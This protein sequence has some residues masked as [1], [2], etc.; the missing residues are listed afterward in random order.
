[1]INKSFVI[2]SA[3][4]T[5]LILSTGGLIFVFN[6]N[7]MHAIYFG[8]IATVLITSKVSPRKNIFNASIY[9]I[10]T[11]LTIYVVNFVFAVN[12]QAIEKFLF[13]FLISTICILVAYHF[14]NN[15]SVERFLRVLYFCLQLIF[16]HS[17]F[18]FL[19]F[20]LVKNNL[21][22]LTS[23]FHECQTFFN[24]FFY[25]IEKSSISI[26]NIDFCRNQG[27]FWEPGILQAYLNLLFFLEAFYF[28]NRKVFLMLIAFVVITTY[29]TAGLTILLI[30]S[31][32][33]IYEEVKKS[34]IF[35]FIAVLLL[36]PVIFIYSNNIENKIKGDYESSFQKRLFDLTQP[37]FIALQNPITG[38]GL[39]VIQFQE[40]RKEFYFNSKR[41]NF[42]QDQIG[43]Q[44]KSKTTE[45]GSS[46]SVMF[47]LATLGFPFT[48][49]LLYFVFKQ[50]F[51]EQKK[52]LFFIFFFLTIMS[53]PLL[54]RP[55][56]FIFII[57]GMINI[58]SKF[59]INTDL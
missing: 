39:D 28:K 30:Q 33:Y 23:A 36:V 57:S 1:M 48:I 52:I 54:L 22:T 29:S 31:I 42:L 4:V 10:L 37:F 26:F 7:L 38:V 58:Y 55:F 45:K 44:S 20:F 21:Q 11:I 35:G 19:A 46:N 40:V 47:L 43:I 9:S 25:D 2:D 53:Q 32:V 34:K 13:N 12:E 50:S 15:R 14:I 17:L 6:R 51:F 18:N 56:F 24:I 27:L 49:L 3:I 8:F 5:L 59:R 16:F 41:L